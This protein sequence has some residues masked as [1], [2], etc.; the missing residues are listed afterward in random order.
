MNKYKA[1]I[2]IKKFLFYE[3]K[4]GIKFE[5]SIKEEEIYQM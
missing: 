1:P 4:T 3:K 2:L 5:V